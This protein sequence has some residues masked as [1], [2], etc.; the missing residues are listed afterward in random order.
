M[1]C[2]RHSPSGT[3]SEWAKR[4][5]LDGYE[6]TQQ[7]CSAYSSARI[8]T[9]SMIRPKRHAITMPWWRLERHSLSG[10]RSIERNAEQQNVWSVRT[11]SIR[12][13]GIQGQ[14]EPDDPICSRTPRKIQPRFGIGC[15][16]PR[17]KTAMR[18]GKPISGSLLMTKPGSMDSLH[19]RRTMPIF[20]HSRKCGA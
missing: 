9:V 19:C 4:L 8:V 18:S 15:A 1:H 17:F 7:G 5:D 13:E 6:S 14:H 11:G 20:Q 10:L 12:S 2:V 16:R 3:N